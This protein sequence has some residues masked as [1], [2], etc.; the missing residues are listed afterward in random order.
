MH[1]YEEYSQTDKADRKPFQLQQ[2]LRCYIF[3]NLR[4][5]KKSQERLTGLV[6]IFFRKC[7]E[8]E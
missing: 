8:T 7:L 3:G 1:A 4:K 5:I 2:T 6:T